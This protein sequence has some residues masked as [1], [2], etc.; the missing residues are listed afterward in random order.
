M[1]SLVTTAFAHRDRLGKISRAEL[2]FEDGGTVV[3]TKD[4]IAVLTVS[5]QTDSGLAEVKKEDLVGIEFPQFDTIE[6]TWSTSSSGIPYKAVSFRFGSDDRKAFGE[7][8]EVSF[9]FYGGKYHHR[10]FKKK[11]S[12][13]SWRITDVEFGGVESILNPS[14]QKANPTAEPVSPSKPGSP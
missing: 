7:F 6:M 14:S 1:V 3:I 8:P 11:I 13:D 5:L 4:R 10:S 2:T 9:V 12:A